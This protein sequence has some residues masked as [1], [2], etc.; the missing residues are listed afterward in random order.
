MRILT[1]WLA[2]PLLALAAANTG[3]PEPPT[4]MLRQYCFGCHGK[5][6]QAAGINLEHLTDPKSIPG[7]HYQKWRK[8]AA[9]LDEKRMPPAKMPQPAEDARAQAANWIR[10]S[11][12]TYF[13]QHAGDPGRVTVRRLTSGEYGYTI[14]DLTGLDMKFDRDFVSDSVGGEGFANFGDV[15]FMQDASLERYLQT[16][17]HIAAHAVIGSGPIQFFADPGKSGFE[18]SAITRINDIYNAFGFRTSS[19]EGGKPF[20]VDRYGKALYACWQYKHRAALGQSQ[21]TIATIAL[22]QGIT[23]RFAEHLWSVL[24]DKTATFPTAEA[25]ERWD[26]IPG[27][28][29]AKAEAP[30]QIADLQKFIVEWPRALLGA[31]EAAAGGLGDERALVINEENIAAKSTGRIKFNIINRSREASRTAKVYLS[32]AS[33]NPDAA[34][35]PV[36]RWRNATLRFRNVDRSFGPKQ[37]L[38]A[39]VDDA[40]RERLKFG[41]DGVAP[42]DFTTTGDAEELIEIVIPPGGGL[43]ELD[44]NMEIAQGSAEGAVV[45]CMLSDKP[46]IFSGRP[47]SAIL[48]NP[49]SAGYK[50]W[51]NNVL[52]FAAKLPSNS[53]GEAAP[54]DKDPIP[55]PYDNT[56]N[57]RE[58]D[59]FHPK[60]KYYRTDKF[61]YENVL[62]GATKLKLNQAWNDLLA[63]FDYHDLFLQFVVEKYK[64]DSI[65]GKTIAQLDDAI[66]RTLPAEPR[67]YIEKL[68]AEFLAVGDAQLSGQPGHV[69]DALRFAA[70]AWR[71]PLSPPEKVDLRAFYDKHR[72]NVT[73]HEAIR[74]LLSRILVSPEFL[75]RLEQTASTAKPTERALSPFELA[76]RMSYF[77]WSSIPDSELERAALAGELNDPK[78]LEKQVR[79]MLQHPKARRMSTEFFGQWLGFYRFDQFAGV[80]TTRFPEFTEEVKNGMYDEATSFFEHIVRNDRPVREMFTANYTFVNEP[81]AK[82]YGIKTKLNSPRDVERIETRGGAFRLGAVLTAT[83]A[84]LRTSPV[85]RGDWVL[86]RILGT[87]TP[88]PPADAGSLPGDDKLFG[89]LTLREKLASHQRNASCA[90]CHSRIDPMGFPL[91]KYDAVGRW[92]ETYQ[93]GKPIEDASTT[94]DKKDIKGVGGLIDYLKGQEPQVLRNMAQKLIGF[95]LGRTAQA[96]DEMLIEKLA[97]SGGETSVAKMASE[98]VMSRQFRYR[99]QEETAATKTASN[100]GATR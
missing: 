33:V 50:K 93:D 40:T 13:E 18:T 49:E 67:K 86:R 98:I 59:A 51:K 81:L 77:L 45:R 48:A 84:P 16:A 39:M 7:E 35:K 5:A 53:H 1:M 32:A 95:A 20:G 71:R 44:I 72:K 70:K 96:S 23:A 46:G 11:L 43:F 73:H 9:V 8:I 41:S 2:I 65:K 55:E 22:S 57:Q 68:R 85:K 62:D 47:I 61:L 83:S 76:S 54:S 26:K 88:P 87:P 80:D 52:T 25:I 6:S 34:V 66:V 27:P 63:S 38:Q 69:N 94:A 82:H 60:V 74:L 17:K 42:T 36:I 29:S 28:R 12:K 19:G 75:Y 90:G 58:R 64:L 100:R 24:H 3:S 10:T 4:P 56:Y 78:H 92:R 91:E 30:R 97:Q 99:R 15:Q 89:G 79:R 14:Q 31:G 37:D 21:A